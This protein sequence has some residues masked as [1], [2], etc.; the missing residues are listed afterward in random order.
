MK[1]MERKWRQ[2]GQV[3][4]SVQQKFEYDSRNE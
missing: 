3:E 1:S 4:A 2:G